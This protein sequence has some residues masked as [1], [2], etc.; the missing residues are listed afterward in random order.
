MVGWFNRLR[1]KLA[2]TVRKN[3]SQDI[4]DELTAHLEFLE[5]EYRAA[6]MTSEEARA[7]AHR[8]F[9][10][11]ARLAEQSRDLFAFRF[12]EDLRRDSAVALRSIF[13]SPGFAL[14]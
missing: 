8:Q 14:V 13:K 4:D 10:N 5:E 2:A 7:P 11:T 1:L 9:G 12:L 6:G 3:R